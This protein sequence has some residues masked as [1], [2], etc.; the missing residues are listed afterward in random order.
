MYVKRIQKVLLFAFKSFLPNLSFNGFCFH[1]MY[2]SMGEKCSDR[3]SFYNWLLK[4][5]KPHPTLR[6][7][8]THWGILFCI[9]KIWS[10]SLKQS[11]ISNLSLFHMG[12]TKTSNIW[13]KEG[14]FTARVEEILR[15]MTTFDL[16]HVKVVL[17]LPF[18]LFWKWHFQ[19]A[20]SRMHGCCFIPIKLFTKVSSCGPHKPTCIVGDSE[21]CALKKLYTENLKFNMVLFGEIENLKYIENKRVY[22]EL[23]QAVLKRIKHWAS[24]VSFWC[25]WGTN[26]YCG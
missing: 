13:K 16:W 25:T 4:Y 6:L 26:K 15:L 2:D 20:L 8:H 1:N 10:T 5:I 18:A 17:R 7:N 3:C 9:L 14:S 12:E 24:G 23:R 21:T 19:N 22:I 11:T